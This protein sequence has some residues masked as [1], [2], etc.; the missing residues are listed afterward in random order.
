MRNLIHE[1]TTASV[2]YKMMTNFRFD[3]QGAL[4]EIHGEELIP[5]KTNDAIYTTNC[6][7]YSPYLLNC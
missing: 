7:N 2:Q 1:K 3:L 5:I 6:K 4:T